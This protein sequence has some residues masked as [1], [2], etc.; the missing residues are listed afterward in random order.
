[1]LIFGIIIGI[2]IISKFYLNVVFMGF[3]SRGCEVN[4]D[5]FYI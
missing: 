2:L 1:M 4:F 5:L 3:I